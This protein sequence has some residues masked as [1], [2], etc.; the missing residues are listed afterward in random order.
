M[1]FFYYCVTNYHKLNGLK[2]YT[3]VIIQFLWIHCLGVVKLGLLLIVSR[4][5][6]C[7]SAGPPYL[8]E[9]LFQTHLVVGRIISWYC[10]TEIAK[11]LTDAGSLSEAACIPC[12]EA[13]SQHG[14]L[15][16]QGQEGKVCHSNLLRWS[17]IEYPITFAL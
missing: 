8:A 13:I 1:F 4:G 14:S 10:G 5:C 17:L 3:C 9:V 6:H 11:F 16:F 7:I 2:Q 15:L 12:H